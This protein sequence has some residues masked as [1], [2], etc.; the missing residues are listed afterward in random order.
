M[1]EFQALEKRIERYSKMNGR[2]IITERV[3]RIAILRFNRPLVHNALNAAM[4]TQLEKALNEVEND[5]G[6]RV[7]IFTGSG[8]KSF[9]AGSDIKELRHRNPSTG[10]EASTEKQSILNRIE[11]FQIPSIAAINGYAFGFGFELTLSCTLRLV[12]EKATL[13]QL[14]IN[15]GII[16]GAGATQR[17]PRLIGKAK[18]SELILMGRIISAEDAFRIGLVNKVVQHK[19]LM[20][21]TLLWAEELAGKS[22]VAMKYA[23]TAINQG[24][25]VVDLAT[26]LNIE[27]QCLGACYASPDSQEGLKAFLEKRKPKFG[28][29]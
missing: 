29:D 24:I 11:G 4:F 21:E 14:D 25:G 17:L 7:V 5:S 3:N 1:Q 13:G 27:S 9:I 26:G 12:S 23:L 28:D 2:E 22:P 6:I 19:M 18:A 16:P 8:D 10:I 20:E 15:L